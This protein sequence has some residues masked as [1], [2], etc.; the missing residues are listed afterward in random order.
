[1][2]ELKNKRVKEWKNGEMKKLKSKK[3]RVRK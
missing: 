1:M 2:E 3:V